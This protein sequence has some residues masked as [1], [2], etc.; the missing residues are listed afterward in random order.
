VSAGKA[1][2]A[3]RIVL[4]LLYP[5]RLQMTYHAAGGGCRNWACQ[6][7]SWSSEEA[8]LDLET[9]RRKTGPLAHTC[10]KE[11]G[12]SSICQHKKARA[13]S[14]ECGG[15]S[16]CQH[17]K[18]RAGCKEYGGFE[19]LPPHTCDSA[20][21]ARTAGVR[22]SAPTSDSAPDL[23]GMRGFGH[24]PPHATALQ[25]QG[26]RGFEQQLLRGALYP[27]MGLEIFVCAS[28]MR[29][30]PS[31]RRESFTRR[32]CPGFSRRF[33]H[34]LRSVLPFEP[35]AWAPSKSIWRLTT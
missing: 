16:I 11:C 15:S 31:H 1:G 20:P 9:A 10:A 25:L 27:A 18:A 3:A 21:T 33:P 13:G 24:L 12:G 8:G 29:R 7:R 17:K 35:G 2:G 32:C 30:S 28:F 26:L 19:H 34:G 5:R 6:V 4:G 22:A 14:K 23:Q